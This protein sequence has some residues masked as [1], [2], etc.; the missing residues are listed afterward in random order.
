MAGNGERHPVEPT[1]PKNFNT[2]KVHTPR[3]SGSRSYRSVSAS[4]KQKIYKTVMV[5][6]EGRNQEREREKEKG[7][8]PKSALNLLGCNGEEMDPKKNE[9]VQGEVEKRELELGRKEKFDEEGNAKEENSEEKDIGG[10]GKEGIVKEN[11]DDE[12]KS[13]S[14]S[15]SSWRTTSTQRRYIEE[16]EALLREEKLKRI[17]LEEILGHVISK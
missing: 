16:L 4:K 13:V 8:R 12:G 3:S 9:L 14:I 7:N 1:E 17:K 6:D 2:E 5:E 10:E 11:K 15:R